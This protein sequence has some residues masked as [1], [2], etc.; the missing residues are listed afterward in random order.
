MPFTLQDLLNANLPALS[1]DGNDDRAITRFSRELIGA[2][3][4]IYLSISNPDQYFKVQVISVVQDM[5]NRLNQ[6]QN[7]GTIPFTQAGFNLVV[8]AVKDEALYLERIIR[9]LKWMLKERPD[10]F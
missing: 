1:T 3:W 8:Q 4:E 5:I 7:S 6:I 2:E 10:N 9:V